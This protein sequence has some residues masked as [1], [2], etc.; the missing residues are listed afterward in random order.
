MVHQMKFGKLQEL[1]TWLA[2][3]AN[4]YACEVEVIAMDGGELRLKV[5]DSDGKE[6]GLKVIDDLISFHTKEYVQL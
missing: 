2:G 4:V 3:K 6:Y 1:V 5:K